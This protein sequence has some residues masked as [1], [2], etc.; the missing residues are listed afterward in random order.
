MAQK[1]LRF[2]LLKLAAMISLLVMAQICA[3]AQYYFTGE[4]QGLHGDKLQYV[5]IKVRSTGG[6]YRTGADGTFAITSLEP[7]D[8]VSFV[9]E[10]YEP[11]TTVIRSTESLEV[12]LKIDPFSQRAKRDP[13][14]SMRD[15]PA[16]VSFAGHSGGVSY[17]TIKRLL[18]M[19]YPVPAEAVRIEELLSYFNTTYESPDTP[20]A[21]GL[22]SE[23]VR[24]PWNNGQRLLLVN[25]S[26]RKANMA[27][28]PPSNIVLLI[29]VS[30]SMD[31][32]NKLPLIK[33]SLRPLIR[34]LRATD[35][36]SIVQFGKEM[37]V[38]A[39]V[40]GSAKDVLI[41]A[42]EQLQPDGPSPGGDGLRLA[43]RVARHQFIPGG[44]NRIIFA[45]DGDICNKEDALALG[46]YIGE[47]SDAGIRLSC[48]GVGVDD[49]TS[50]ELPFFADRGKGHFTPVAEEE[51]GERA[52]LRE[53]TLGNPIADNVSVT[54]QFDTTLGSGYRLI[55]FDNRPGPLMDTTLQRC[56]VASCQSLMAVFEYTPKRDTNG[57]IAKI[58][59][60]YC[61]PGRSARQ[62]VGYNCPDMPM[63][64]GHANACLRK[65]ICVALFGMK[66]K[67]AGYDPDVSWGEIQK[68]AKLAFSGTNYIDRE[69]LSL[70]ARAKKIYEGKDDRSASREYYTSP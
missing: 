44:N 55:G 61:Q 4:V 17:H 1:L 29:D 7:E 18:D 59:V 38:M 62:T 24:C 9:C 23:L 8:T 65:E 49:S 35:T 3:N 5:A 50:M 58:T 68:L 46:D 67:G 40:P 20:A 33:A 31:M 28:I 69:Y 54:A 22:S 51:E 12:L 66:L 52:M 6:V 47:Q 27:H 48:I 34:N 42:I 19:G 2:G 21:F 11:Y 41:S 43:Y 15:G 70:V 30:G 16:T 64:F 53:L 56:S 13:L 14:L 32:P 37:R 25:I 57:A 45:T 39:G 63:S 60:H 10:G 36:V 26:G